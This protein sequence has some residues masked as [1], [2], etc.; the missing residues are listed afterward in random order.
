MSDA[1]GTL[2]PER[3][4]RRAPP[5]LVLAAA[6]LLGACAA[7]PDPEAPPDEETSL[8][9]SLASAAVDVL[10]GSATA[11]EVTV[12]RGGQ[13]SG[14]VILAVTGA[15]PQGVSADLTPVELG[16]G[17]TTSV[18]RIAA[19]AEAEA[20]TFE[21]EVEGTA[22]GTGDHAAAT[23]RVDVEGLVVEGTVLDLFGRP[24]RNV[25]V[26]SQGKRDRTLADGTFT[27]TD[28]AVPYD[29]MLGRTRSPALHEYQG[30]T[31]PEPRLV[32][33]EQFPERTVVSRAT[34][35]G[36]LAGGASL[37]PDEQV[38]LC[39]EGLDGL[40]YGC[41][42]AGSAD[43][44]LELEWGQAEPRSVRVH[45]IHARIAGDTVLEFLGY[46]AFEVTVEDGDALTH[47]LALGPV[48]TQQLAG[49]LVRG[50][51]TDPQF[52]PFV[53][54]ALRFGDGLTMP[55]SG[56]EATGA[57]TTPV[58]ALPGVPW[59]YEVLAVD[60][61]ITAVTSSLEWRDAA[62]L[63]AGEIVLEDVPRQVAPDAYFDRV[64][65][66]TRFEVAGLTG[67]VK[68]FM[69]YDPAFGS[70]AFAVTTS[71]DVVTLPDPEE[72][73]LAGPP[74]WGDYLWG[75][76][77]TL[78]TSV[79]EAAASMR[80]VRSMFDALVIGEGGAASAPGRLVQAGWREF[81]FA[82]AVPP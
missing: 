77:S 31:A 53:V 28:L 45:A 50:A 37:P 34:I 48:Q 56:V 41:A 29:L 5:A 52:D 17:E 27:L 60:G 16:T 23:L 74:Y 80:A 25:I 3:R 44:L 1:I 13:R 32:F 55:V 49:R 21:L 69:W 72:L 70:P 76:S 9:L 51:G 58:P 20:G 7:P 11:V 30:L 73:G 75:V 4:R 78:D 15:L 14:E 6:L 43:Y 67:K 18:L 42:E 61:M 62:G 35:D 24:L 39:A 2:V 59:E 40:V 71:A 57:F 33:L 46:E 68:T 64:T 8:S 38:R 65:L 82:G 19:T 36:A 12:T 63:D 47:D 81:R 54:A 26:G 10:R 22:S 79:D 66:A